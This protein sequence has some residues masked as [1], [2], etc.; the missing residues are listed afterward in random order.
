MEQQ[1]APES[2]DSELDRLFTEDTLRDKGASDLFLAYYFAADGTAS[3]RREVESGPFPMETLNEKPHLGG[4]FFQALWEGD[5]VQALRRA[6]TKNHAILAHLTGKT[7][8]D[9]F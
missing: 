7:R 8:E 9:T 1:T 5:E 4:G 6:D 2:M 3:A